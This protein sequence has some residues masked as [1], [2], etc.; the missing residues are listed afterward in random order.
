M[1][2]ISESFYKSGATVV[3]IFISGWFVSDKIVNKMEEITKPLA[4]RVQLLEIRQK[5][6]EIKQSI[7]VS[8]ISV[9]S[10]KVAFNEMCLNKAIGFLNRSFS[11]EFTKP[12]EIY[13]QKNK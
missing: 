10:Y 11:Q 4:D 1:A 13:I 5:D 12:D 8:D 6:Y 3:A 2:L 9:I 7:I